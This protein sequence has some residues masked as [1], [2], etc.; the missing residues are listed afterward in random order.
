MVGRLVKSKYR[1]RAR[2][3][4]GGFG[5]VVL[6]NQ[7]Q[8]EIDLGEVVLKFLHG[9]V[10][11]N[12]SVRRRF[13]N[14]ARA[15]R[16]IRS[17]HVVKVF[18]L[19]FDE[20]GL[21]FM[22][23]EY[24]EGVSLQE[25]MQRRGK[26]SPH[27]VFRIGLQVANALEESH[28]AGIIH[29][30]LKPDNLLMLGDRSDD[31]VKVLD[32]GIAR[33]P[34]A[35]GTLTHTFMGTPRYMPPEQI[36][37]QEI[38]GGV[39][40][41][42]LGVILYE[43]LSGRPPIQAMT[44][45]EYLQLNLSARPTPL[46]QLC[47][48]MPVPLEHLLEEMMAKSRAD[49]PA[50]MARVEQRLRTVGVAN[51]WIPEDTGK[52]EIRG[53]EIHGRIIV[54]SGTGEDEADDELH[55]QAPAPPA[56]V[57]TVL[58]QA[59]DERVPAAGGA[60]ANDPLASVPGE[61]TRAERSL[62]G[63]SL[64]WKLVAAAAVVLLGT[65]AVLALSRV[66]SGRQGLAQSTRV[67]RPRPDPLQ[68]ASGRAGRLDARP[69]ANAAAARVSLDAAPVLP[70][71]GT[72]PGRTAQPGRARQPERK[73]PRRPSRDDDYGEASGGL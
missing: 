7:V 32:F 55:L 2:L 69:R 3:G 23:M 50:S 30:D 59:A 17:P 28:R 39:D 1:V 37:Q 40:I 67:G 47:P 22:V 41:Y 4:A 48:D 54:E 61:A 60:R 64:P 33:V 44:P 25:L 20:Q 49:R 24:L 26:L 35:R 51:G 65:V 34:S 62:L 5:V 6:A 15:T 53:A 13:I 8:G 38:D 63:R 45:M 52:H 19:D 36:L 27:R 12:P 46:R 9:E 56:A 66:L 21:P 16:K 42:A 11:Q 29:R 14:E 70:A 73:Q 31:F 10:A 57:S 18:D 71:A 72:A 43:C 68:P 58:S